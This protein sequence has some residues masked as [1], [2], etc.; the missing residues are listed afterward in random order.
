MPA[1][2]AGHE[3]QFVPASVLFSYDPSSQTAD[4]PATKREKRRNREIISPNLKKSG[5]L[6]ES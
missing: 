3:I 2:P 4:A 5:M 6:Y 1:L